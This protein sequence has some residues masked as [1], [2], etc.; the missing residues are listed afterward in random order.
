MPVPSRILERVIHNIKHDVRARV[1]AR[2]P[3]V[4]LSHVVSNMSH[5]RVVGHEPSLPS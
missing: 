1:G 4:P 5:T 2:V 3:I